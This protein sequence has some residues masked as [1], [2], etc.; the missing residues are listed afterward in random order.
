MDLVHQLVRRLD[1]DL[2]PLET[3]IDRHASVADA[4]LVRRLNRGYQRFGQSFLKSEDHPRG[5]RLVLLLSEQ[6]GELMQ[7]CLR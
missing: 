4:L 7:N 3:P 2:E 6:I 5:G 1:V